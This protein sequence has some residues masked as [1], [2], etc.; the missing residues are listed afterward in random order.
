MPEQLQLGALDEA[1]AEMLGSL[2]RRGLFREQS[3][4]DVGLACRLRS[5]RRLAKTFRTSKISTAC[6]MLEMRT[7]SAMVV[8]NG[9]T[10]CLWYRCSKDNGSL[11]RPLTRLSNDSI[12]WQLL[13]LDIKKLGR[14]RKPGHRVTGSLQLGTS[15]GAGWEYVHVA[16]DEHSRVTF[17]T[18]EPGETAH[19]AAR[20]LTDTLHHYRA[21]DVRFTRV[22]TDNGACYRSRAFR[23]LLRCLG[24]KHVY[25]RHRGV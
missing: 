25:T 5:R 23:R 13:H 18:I 15:C 24:I 7:H 9:G 4:R 14:F 3:R 16:I 8:C 21:L 11:P 6:R 20:T 1:C 22:L 19:S 17:A 2:G 12:A 10:R